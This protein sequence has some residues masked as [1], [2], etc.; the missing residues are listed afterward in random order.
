VDR[1]TAAEPTGQAAERPDGFALDAAWQQIVGEVERKRSRTWATVLIETR[2]VRILRDHFGRHC[3]TEVDLD[4]GRSRVRIAAPTPLD[5]ARDLAG[6]GAA[7]EV[8]DPPQVQ[9]ELARIGAELLER[10]KPVAVPGGDG[11]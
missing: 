3:H 5:I 4:D 9:V 10:Y 11:S 7:V 1:I 6:W 2:F 8:L